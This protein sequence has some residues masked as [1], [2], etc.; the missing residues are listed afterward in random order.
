MATLSNDF[1]A[2][3]AE[4]GQNEYICVHCDFKCSKKYSWERHILTSK[5]MKAT[6]SNVLATDKGQK[7]QNKIFCCEN[8]GK[9][10]NDRTGLWRHKKKCNEEK[11]KEKDE[12][13]DKE[14]MC[15]L[16]K[17]NSE[18]FKEHSDIKELILEIVKNGTL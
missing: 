16:I 11:E 7:G 3:R 2:K 6:D 10:Y 13:S 14:L 12:P 4:K 9:E 17:Q 1:G 5:H 15:M 8:C 18:L